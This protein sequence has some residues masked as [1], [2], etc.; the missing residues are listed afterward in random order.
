M[1]YIVEMFSDVMTYIPSFVKIGLGTE[2]ILWLLLQQTERLQ[3]WCLLMGG[4]CDI[5]SWGGLKR[6]DT[7]IRFHAY[8]FRNS[9]NIHG[10]T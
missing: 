7:R 3:F 5:C 1:M 9:S 2:V 6:C 8:R 10:I 4:F